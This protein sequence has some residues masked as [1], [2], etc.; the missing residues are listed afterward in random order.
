MKR[1]LPA[2]AV[3]AYAF[4]YL[5]LLVLSAF[6]FNASR[7]TVWQGFTFHWYA[8]AFRNQQMLDAI[9]N[10]LIIGVT[11]SVIAT[12]AGTLAAYGIWKRRAPWL[13]NSLYLSLLTPEIVT[14]ISLL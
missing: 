8:E 10:S 5:P 14:G 11:A 6:S 3:V 2:Y 7:F 9:F 13:T 4:L 12:A 1:L